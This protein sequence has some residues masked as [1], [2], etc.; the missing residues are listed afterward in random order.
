MGH[1]CRRDGDAVRSEALKTGSVLL[2]ACTTFWTSIA[3]S[4]P[5]GSLAKAIDWYRRSTCPAFEPWPISAWSATGQCS[6]SYSLKATL[7]CAL[8]FYCFS[9]HGQDHEHASFFLL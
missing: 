5:A 1:V 2:E 7:E 3:L 4:C 8:I 6:K 9:R